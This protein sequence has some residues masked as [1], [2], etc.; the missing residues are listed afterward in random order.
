MPLGTPPSGGLD[1]FP[2]APVAGRGL[3]RLY[4]HIDPSNGVERSPWWFAS[5]HADPDRGG[6]FDLQEPNGA[7]YLAGSR[8]AAVLEVYQ[9]H[10]VIPASALERR[11]MACVV[12]PDG[13][14]DAADLAC[15][16]ARGYGITGEIHTVPNRPATRA[17]AEA[18]FDAGWRALRGLAR[19]N[20][21]QQLDTVTLLDA[22][23][24]HPPYGD[25]DGWAVELERP[26]T[27]AAL[28]RD[29]ARYG[30]NV[31]GGLH[32]PE[33]VPLEDSGLLDEE[34]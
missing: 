16:A 30:L 27:D 19:H 2:S 23:G 21:A 24:A 6:R 15:A 34:S 22:A 33:F 12:A 7:C 4:A 8:T 29:L 3:F 14:P 18:L 5:A 17:W 20:P 31:Q 9:G 26:A 1:R 28:I 10:Q 13:A 25:E 11:R 32:S